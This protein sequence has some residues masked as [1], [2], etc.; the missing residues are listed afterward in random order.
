MKEKKNADRRDTVIVLVVSFAIVAF[1]CAGV[2]LLCRRCSSGGASAQAAA[3]SA[4]QP[5]SGTVPAES[6]A[7]ADA[8]GFS[9]EPLDEGTRYHYGGLRID[10][11]D[12][13]S[14]VQASEG[15]YCLSNGYL[16]VLFSC[17]NEED[18][19]YLAAEGYTLAD[20]TVEEY[21]TAIADMNQISNENFF[22]DTCDNVVL[23]STAETSDGQ[24]ASVYTVVKKADDTFW[25]IQFT[26]VQAVYDAYLRFFPAWAASVAFD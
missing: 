12:G 16:D 19:A 6:T 25:C 10:M 17:S 3:S 23:Y 14:P 13:F 15:Y 7:A 9:S 2:L 1:L 22:Y 26:G 24:T 18:K 21:A 4:S 11:E 8:D 5:A 20:M